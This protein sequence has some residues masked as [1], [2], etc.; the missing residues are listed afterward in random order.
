MRAAAAVVVSLALVGCCAALRNAGAIEVVDAPPYSGIEIPKLPEGGERVKRATTCGT[1]TTLNA[2]QQ[3]ESVSQHNRWR[4]AEPAS[5]VFTMTWSDSL[6]A[7]AQNWTNQCSWQHGN[8]YDCSGNRVG[9]NLYMSYGSAGYPNLNLTQA[10]T[11]WNN[12]RSDWN[13]TSGSCNANKVCGHW[14]QL[15]WST[16]V[17]VGCS[18]TQCPVVT[19]AAG[20]TYNNVIYVA[21]DYYPAGNLVGT[22]FYTPGTPCTNCW[23]ITRAG[24]T[25][26]G[27][28]CD[29]TFGAPGLCVACDPTTDPAC[30]CGPADTCSGHGTWST[31]T[32]SCTCNAGYFGTSCQSSCLDVQT[33]SSCQYWNGLGY[34]AT[35][36]TYYS[37]MKTNC[38]YTC[39]LCF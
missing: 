21:C 20:N 26:K 11:L 14:T 9:Q 19:D 18:Y 8:L 3:T 23:K 4:S 16:S 24:A 2:N 17:Q 1:T 30:G 36:S 29:A 13:W 12:E 15:V 38:V 27:F 25:N 10:I 5:D 35:T 34:C 32:C 28:K 39:G 7:L 6:A 37:F 33:A 31:T 22:S